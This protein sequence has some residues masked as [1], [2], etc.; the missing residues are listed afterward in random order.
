MISLKTYQNKKVMAMSNTKNAM[1]PFALN[2]SSS[3]TGIISVFLM[4]QNYFAAGVQ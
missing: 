2:F 1:A 4:E 3:L